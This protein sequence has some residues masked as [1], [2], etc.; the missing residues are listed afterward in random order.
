MSEFKTLRYQCL[1]CG[2]KFSEPEKYQETHGLDSPPYE[3]WYGCPYCAGA[4]K[5]I[6]NKANRR[7]NITYV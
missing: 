5:E 4:Y 3:E 6:P 7:R 2:R 1:D